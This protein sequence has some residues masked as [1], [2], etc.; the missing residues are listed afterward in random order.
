MSRSLSQLQRMQHSCILAGLQSSTPPGREAARGRQ[1]RLREHLDDTPGIETAVSCCTWSLYSLHTVAHMTL[2]QL[3][4]YACRNGLPQLVPMCAGQRVQPARQCKKVKLSPG[5][6]APPTRSK[7]GGSSVS[8]YS[9]CPAAAAGSHDHCY[10]ARAKVVLCSSCHPWVNRICR[11]VILQ[12]AA[13]WSAQQQN[14]STCC[15]GDCTAVSSYWIP[16]LHPLQT[17][18]YLLPPLLC[19]LRSL[20]HSARSGTAVSLSNVGTMTLV[21]LLCCLLLRAGSCGR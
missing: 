14:I 11:I 8:C 16:T 2:L 9:E 18:T 1:K 19:Y 20:S 12:H 6:T 21:P 7:F 17:P 10:S 15:Y 5:L 13:C 3:A 4:R